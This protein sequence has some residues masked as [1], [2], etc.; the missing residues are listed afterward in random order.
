MYETFTVRQLLDWTEEEIWGLDRPKV[1][2]L[3]FDDGEKIETDTV[4]IIISWYYWQV[5]CRYRELTITRKIYLNG[6]PFR[7]ELH[8]KLM[9]ASI[10]ETVD[11]RDINREDVWLISFRETYN[12]LYNAIVTHLLP[13]IATTNVPDILELLFDEEI[14]NANMRVRPT[15]K[16]VEKVYDV[17]RHI[18]NNSEKYSHNPI[19]RAVRNR[20]VPMN[21][22]LQ[23]ICPRGL[24]TD[25]DSVIFKIPVTRG[26]AQGFRKSSDLAKESRSAAKALLFN[27]DP[28]RTAEY[29]NRKLQLVC[30][31]VKYIKGDDCGTHD[32]HELKIPEADH[33]SENID[34][35]G[36][37]LVDSMVGLYQIMDDGSLREIMAGDYHLCGTT[38]KFRTTLCCKHLKHQR[39]CRH[40]YGSIAYNIP[41][42]TNLGH[43]SCTEINKR[44]T[45][46]IIST[47]H[48]DFIIYRFMAILRGNEPVYLQ[49]RESHP[50]NIYLNP[51]KRNKRI[52]I[53]FK[54]EDVKRLVDIN[55][56]DNDTNIT[57]TKISCISEVVMWEF[58][59]NGVLF[60]ENDIDTTF[61]M[62]KMAARPSLSIE[63]LKYL[64]NKSWSVT[65]NFVDILLDADWNVK[66]P[67]FTYPLKHDNM[68]EYR[69]R[70][71]KFIRSS[72]QIG[73]DDDDSERSTMKSFKT[74]KRQIMLSQYVDPT[75]ALYD[76]WYLIS[77]KLSGV[78]LG[79]IATIAAATRAT[80]P[81]DYN[82][83]MPTS[84]TEGSFQSH[85]NLI[86]HRDLAVA[87]LYQKQYAVFDELSS[88]LSKDRDSNA[89]QDLIYI[90]PAKAKAYAD[91]GGRILDLD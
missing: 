84:L 15:Q 51:S 16:S 30:S 4:D 6:E 36:K 60:T 78:N 46:L 74:V 27:K 66:D 43:V 18:I 69:G 90:S 88:Y 87:M 71:E 72:S 50:E 91:N 75:K 9:W 62:T 52:L 1:V 24:L 31:N 73:P 70:V 64:R 21:Q 47:K 80:S 53:R 42:D 13:Y 61:D 68:S 79:H 44:I 86:Q 45:Q 5:A 12:K 40:C 10:E 89:L 26:F 11:R 65:G 33:D 58:D 38:V 3:I 37:A 28:V 25:I 2:N 32:Y 17:A 76:A 29:F 56:I 35:T 55:Y 34:S 54:A 20:T 57:P 7:D 67:I 39:V 41:E 77:E 83:H 85:E 59:E 81:S 48:L 14:H 63:M 22:I 49:T 19:V 82:Y 8:R 23:S